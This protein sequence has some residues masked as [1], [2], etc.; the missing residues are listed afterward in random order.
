[1]KDGK[2][3]ILCID[4]DPDFLES[5]R[6]ILESGDYVIETA[7]SGEEGL[8]KYKQARPDLVLVDLMMEE[9]DA[10]TNFVRDVR[11]LG[12]TPPLLMLSSVGDDLN[13]ST[14]YS[15]LGLQGV[16]QKPIDPDVLLSTLDTKLKGRPSS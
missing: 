9:V 15:Q 14:D 11:A 7:E 2:H 10:G 5:I 8:R 4:D 13:I 3:V 16:L 12:P 1:M 6:M